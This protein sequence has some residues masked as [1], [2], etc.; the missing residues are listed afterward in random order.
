MCLGSALKRQKKKKK[1]K[2]AELGD[3]ILSA[4]P[5]MGESRSLEAQG[6]K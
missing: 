3:L 6:A 4:P 2:E 1:K 5:T